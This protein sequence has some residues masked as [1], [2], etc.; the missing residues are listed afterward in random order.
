MTVGEL[1]S[2]LAKCD[3]DDEPVLI[4][5]LVEEYDVWV[6]VNVPIRYVQYAKTPGVFT[7]FPED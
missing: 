2:A 6:R 5:I 1:K 3:Y 7:I 4:E